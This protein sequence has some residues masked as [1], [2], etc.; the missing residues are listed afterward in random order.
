[1]DCLA[2]RSDLVQLT[3]S[4]CLTCFLS[5]CS[6][7]CDVVMTQTPLAIAIGSMH[8]SLKWHGIVKDMPG[9]VRW[10]AA[11]SVPESHILG[12]ISQLLLDAKLL[13]A[14]KAADST[15][16]CAFVFAFASVRV[17]HAPILSTSTALSS[18]RPC[19]CHVPALLLSLQCVICIAEVLT[20]MG[21]MFRECAPKVLAAIP[22]SHEAAAASVHAHAVG[23]GLSASAP[24]TTSEPRNAEQQQAWLQAKAAAIGQ[25]HAKQEQ[26]GT[27][28][29]HGSEQTPQA[30]AS[31]PQAA[32]MP[33][34]PS[35]FMPTAPTAQRGLD[36]KIRHDRRSADRGVPA[37]PKFAVPG[38]VTSSKTPKHNSPGH[39][40]EPP[41]MQLIE[42]DMFH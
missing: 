26:Y 12:Q 1:M 38:P 34:Q 36:H 35:L 25:H 29:S 3:S 10:Y 21:E 15:T 23:T 5:E 41:Q 17:G 4:S 8:F 16:Q 13:L 18:C 40:A 24:T 33:V 32:N 19:L 7:K 39:V 28:S 30:T 2:V 31:Q 22:S 37:V 42:T 14:C 27:S 20:A 11:W 6:L 9:G